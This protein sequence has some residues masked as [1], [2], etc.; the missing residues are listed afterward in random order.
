MENKLEIAKELYEQAYNIREK[1]RI[2]RG[3]ATL[4]LK[5]SN[6]CVEA[7]EILKDY[8]SSSSIDI[9]TKFTLEM[10][11]W[12]YL[13][14]SENMLSSYYYDLKQYKLAINH[15][16]K[17]SQYLSES[18]KAINNAITDS[19]CPN[20][21]I[22]HDNIVIW[23]FYENSLLP[24]ELSII[25][26]LKWEKEEY[27]SS[28]DYYKTAVN[29]AEVCMND[30]TILVN[31]GKL[32]PEFKRIGIGNYI[33]MTA[34]VSAALS[35]IIY[36]KLNKCHDKKYEDMY[37]DLLELFFR[38]YILSKNA[39]LE[40]PEWEHYSEGSYIYLNNIK[41]LLTQNKPLWK[42]I[43]L[44]FEENKELLEIMKDIDK[45]KY[46]KIRR[47]S[48]KYDKKVGQL[49][50]SG[51][52]FLLLFVVILGLVTLS[53]N[54]I[55]SFWTFLAIITSVEIILLLVSAVIL[56]I[57]GELSEQGFLKLISMAF[58]NQLSFLEI[59]KGDKK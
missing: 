58:K 27:I 53:A 8:V 10:Y 24:N 36:T 34:N 31:Q 28:L 16:R 11:L 38:V 33:A 13:F 1:A 18:I 4:Y 12:Y 6:K 44:K 26:K 59:F 22:F 17:S 41:I 21:Q 56:K 35:Q 43:Y 19:N 47:E 7:S 49:W 51:S 37:I 57:Q 15:L 29:K 42:K 55:K 39:Y 50:A 45:K 9:Y 54:I 52:F 5:A 23:K 20:K 2:S 25:A 40:N 32:P 14:E 46:N 48:D 3:N 30:S